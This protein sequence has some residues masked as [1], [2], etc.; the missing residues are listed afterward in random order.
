VADDEY[1]ELT[2]WKMVEKGA[3]EKMESL[4]YDDDNF[5][6]AVSAVEKYLEELSRLDA[7]AARAAT[8]VSLFLSFS[9][10]FSLIF[11]AFSFLFS[12]LLPF[13]LV[14]RQFYMF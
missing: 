14:T 5:S 9:F 11:F 1:S 10:S 2:L 6:L 3:L 8:A 4:I 13:F 7:F 12:F